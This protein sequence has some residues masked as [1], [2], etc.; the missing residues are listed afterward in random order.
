[1]SSFIELG[2]NLYAVIKNGKINITGIKNIP[3]GEREKKLE[4]LRRN[5]PEIENRLVSLGLKTIRSC[6]AEIHKDLNGIRFFIPADL[7]T[8]RIA[9]DAFMDIR[10]LLKKRAARNRT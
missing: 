8:A 5:L 1:M 3:G 6:G 2:N 7:E 4:E 10:P 9:E